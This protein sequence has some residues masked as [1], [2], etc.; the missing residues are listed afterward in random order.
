MGSFHPGGCG[1][2][3]HVTTM[4]A[5]LIFQV[6]FFKLLPRLTQRLIE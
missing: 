6:G 1:R 3:T 5:Q 2:L 4:L